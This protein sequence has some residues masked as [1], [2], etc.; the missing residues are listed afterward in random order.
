MRGGK[1]EV[2]LR[3]GGH[4]S[5]L[6]LIQMRGGLLQGMER[7]EAET[8]LKSCTRCASRLDQARTAAAEFDRDF[9]TWESLKGSAAPARPRPR[10]ATAGA[11]W[12]ERVL[13][14]LGPGPGPRIAFV[15]LLV[16]LA[17]G[18]TF[19]MRGGAPAEDALTPKGQ[20]SAGYYLFVNGVR[21]LRDT[22]TAGP[23]DSLQLG[24][25]GEAPVQYAVLYQDDAGAVE[26]YMVDGNGS[27][28]A[29]GSP[30]GDNLPHSLILKGTWK[31]EMLFCLS[32]PRRFTLA[33]ALARVRLSAGAKVG[34]VVDSDIRLRTFILNSPR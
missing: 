2:D 10:L 33:E 17:V 19:W 13:D 28:R 3:T 8:H 22:V 20:A 14:L 27:Q 25:A 21:A 16:L 23:G 1:P 6:A 31:R 18:T 7:A 9:P 12:W 29:L 11:G 34:G 32:S 24:L 5:R 15:G 30:A 26:P 4:L